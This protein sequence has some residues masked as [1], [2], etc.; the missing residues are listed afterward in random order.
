MVRSATHTCLENHS[1]IIYNILF[2]PVY[3]FIFIFEI[4]SNNPSR[5]QRVLRSVWPIL[6]PETVRAKRM[7]T[8]PHRRSE[9]YTHC[10]YCAGNC[11]NT[12][13]DTVRNKTRPH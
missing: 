7:I 10:Q 6:I 9:V 2:V 5:F 4:F 8:F 1:Y 3:A 12:H 13:A 11:N